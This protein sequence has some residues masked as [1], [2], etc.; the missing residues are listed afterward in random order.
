[1]AKVHYRPARSHTQAGS[2]RVDDRASRTENDGVERETRRHELERR[3]ALPDDD[4][5]TR[6]LAEAT[7]CGASIEPAR[8]SFS[9]GEGGSAP[10]TPADPS[11]A[12]DR[13]DAPGARALPNGRRSP[14]GASLATRSVTRERVRSRSWVSRARRSSMGSTSTWLSTPVQSRA[15]A[16]ARR[17][18][19][20]RPS[21]RSRSVVGQMQAKA[22]ACAEEPGLVRLEVRRVDG[23]EA[24]GQDAAVRQELDRAAPGLGEA[25]VHLARLLGDVHVQRASAWAAAYSLSGASHDGGTARTE[26]GATPTTTSGS[27]AQRARSVS[28][29][30]RTSSTAGRRSGAAPPRPRP[31]PARW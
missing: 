13:S 4:L 23:H 22:R 24:L 8:Q 30:R 12:A 16:L 29:S 5:A 11:N 2:T 25:L 6:P 3:V 26:C 10:S 31:G 28:T 19:S 21:P 18:R 1:M 17:P 15:P 14:A 9:A 20:G 7:S 27:P